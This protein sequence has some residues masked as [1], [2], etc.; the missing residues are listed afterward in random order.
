MRCEIQHCGDT[1]LGERN[2]RTLTAVVLCRLDAHPYLLCPAEIA[3]CA[4]V[5]DLLFRVM[6]PPSLVCTR[7]QK[8]EFGQ[9]SQEKLTFLEEEL[10]C[11]ELFPS[12]RGDG[13]SAALPVACSKPFA[14]LP[15]PN[16]AKK[17]PLSLRRPLTD[18]PG[19]LLLPLATAPLP[20]PPAG[21]R[22]SQP[23]PALVLPCDRPRRFRRL[24]DASTLIHIGRRTPGPA[25]LTT[26]RRLE[27]DIDALSC[28]YP[29]R[30]SSDSG[31]KSPYRGSEGTRRESLL[32]PNPA[33]RM[34]AGLL[35]ATEK[36]SWSHVQP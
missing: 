24:P 20:L 5:A 30:S 33:A 13:S 3:T 31:S 16:S 19:I 26:S 18:D 7:G 15:L 14:G 12:P 28:G 8:P 32:L 10:S 4:I 21:E 6:S 34:S 2:A 22:L 23:L 29:R 36:R 25:S 9:G 35:L 27:N 1:L 17:R 11:D